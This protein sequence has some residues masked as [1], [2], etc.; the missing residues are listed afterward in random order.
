M[1]AEKTVIVSL[2]GSLIVP[3][4]DQI[5][6]NFIKNFKKLVEEKIDEGYRFVLIAGGGK[7]ARKYIEAAGKVDEIEDDDKDWLGIHATRMNAHFVKTILRKN[8]HPIINKNPNETQE[9]EESEKPVLIASGWRPGNSTDFVAVTLAKHLGIKKIIN[10]SN[11][12]YLYDKDPSKFFTA[13]R[14]KQST[15]TDFREMVGN[16]WDPGMNVPF[17]PIASKLAEEERIEV[18]I[19]NGENLDSLN[20]YLNKEEFEGTLIS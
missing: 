5:N 19:I 4:D 9:F 11:I 10:L 6:V 20:K 12:D 16:K 15:W 13:K 17:D 8:A 3:D 18:A 2:G 1:E 7:I 14:I